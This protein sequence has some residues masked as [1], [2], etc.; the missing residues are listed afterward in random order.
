MQPGVG[1]IWLN[2][3]VGICSD[4]AIMTTYTG[5]HAMDC[6]LLKLI[7]AECTKPRTGKLMPP[8]PDDVSVRHK[9]ADYCVVIK[10]FHDP[11]NTP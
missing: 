9:G 1:R 5:D 2:Y 8:A 11:Q 6:K 10:P 4:R 3:L 7:S